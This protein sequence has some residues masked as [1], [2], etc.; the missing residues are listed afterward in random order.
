MASTAETAAA[1]I[2][3]I[4]TAAGMASGRV[5]RDRTTAFAEEESPAILVEIIEDDAEHFG[6]VQTSVP[7]AAFDRL[8]VSLSIT[9]MTR[10]DDWQTQLD[11]LRQQAHGLLLADEALATTLNGFRRTTANWDSA[12]ADTPFGTLIQRYSGKTVVDSLQL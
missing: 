9:Y 1:R 2:A 12:T 5:F 8:M 11:T 7:G 6:G 10:S 3:S 4:L